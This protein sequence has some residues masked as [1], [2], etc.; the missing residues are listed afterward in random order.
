MVSPGNVVPPLRKPAGL[1]ALDLDPVRITEPPTIDTGVVRDRLDDLMEQEAPLET[2]L[3]TAAELLD[4]P[5][6][7]RL[8][9][10]ADFQASPAKLLTT[11]AAPPHAHRYRL[12]DGVEAWALSPLVDTLTLRRLGL[13]CRQAGH[14]R[15]STFS[16]HGQLRAL[17]EPGTDPEAR[18]RALRYLR[19][20]A[21]GLVTVVALLGEE[22]ATE[23]VVEQIR[24]QSG[25]AHATPIDG[26][27]LCLAQGALTITALDVPVGLKSAVAAP[28]RPDAVP[29]AWRQARIGLRFALPSTHGKAPYA[30]GE[31]VMVRSDQLGGYALLADKLDPDDIDRVHDVQLLDQLCSEDDDEM[32]RTLEAVSSTD[33][34]RKAAQSVH[35]HHNS[36]AR[37]V[38]RAEHVLGFGFTEPYGRTRLFLALTLRRIRGSRDL[39]RT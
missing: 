25:L 19:L 27:T 9:N 8:A 3:V 31:A 11:G 21:T 20:P 30:V 28:C 17:V 33:S 15:E 13:A 36:V 6:G 1:A 37:R 14:R 32:L 29:Q 2:I 26:V 12:P 7:V 39:G 4:C 5:V 23:V 35:M 16:V 34:L 10:G 24:R 38:E 22:A 18:G